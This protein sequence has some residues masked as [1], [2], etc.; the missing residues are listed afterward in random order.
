MQGRIGPDVIANECHSVAIPQVTPT[1]GNNVESTAIAHALVVNTWSDG[2]SALLSVNTFGCDGERRPKMYSST[3]FQG[4]IEKLQVVEK[5]VSDLL[6]EC[7]C[8]FRPSSWPNPCRRTR[9]QEINRAFEAGI[10]SYLQ[11]GQNDGVVTPRVHRPE[12]RITPQISGGEH[13]N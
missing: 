4:T 9:R 7:H 6:R 3:G 2:K 1:L 5:R 10:N 11:F 12:G 13:G 8:E